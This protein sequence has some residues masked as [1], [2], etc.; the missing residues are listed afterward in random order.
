MKTIG[1]YI[2]GIAGLLAAAAGAARADDPLAP[3]DRA[4]AQ[5]SARAAPAV[6]AIEVGRNPAKAGAPVEAVPAVMPGR[7]RSL[8]DYYTRPKGPVSGVVLE[9]DG[10][11]LTSYYNVQG[12]VRDV[13][14]L[15][16]GRR[17]SAVLVG[18]SELHDIALLKVDA[19]N[20][21]TLEAA[22]PEE[23]VPGRLCVLVGRSPVPDRPTV[24]WGVVSALHRWED[25]SLQTDAEMNFGSAG[26]AL[27][28]LD[29]RLLG[30]SSHI[31]DRTPW[32][33]SSGV[34]FATRLEKI[35]EILPRLKAGEKIERQI[36][37]LGVRFSDEAEGDGVRIVHVAPD[38]PGVP[39][40]ADKAGLQAGD[41][42]LEYGEKP[43]NNVDLLIEELRATRPGTTVKI[44][45]RRGNDVREVD[46]TLINKPIPD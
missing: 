1:L 29:G 4:I 30:I 10:W 25:T 14:V 17:L 7:T 16:E 3:L 12:E 15:H 45:Y 46:V 37:Y 40:P 31:A 19:K 8:I 39:S 42:I 5:A 38:R 35:R 9:P 23:T 21:Q 26:G 36:G 24:T 43:V 41:V 18:W 11:I 32:G 44:R 20:L 6:V 13:A 2:P 22:K 28:D 34:G 33:Q 27:V